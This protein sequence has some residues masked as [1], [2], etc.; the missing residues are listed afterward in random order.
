[1]SVEIARRFSA[2]VESAS[3]TNTDATASV[4]TDGSTA[5]AAAATAAAG[6]A[7][8]GAGA[9]AVGAFTGKSENNIGIIAGSIE[10][11]AAHGGG[12]GIPLGGGGHYSTQ[13]ELHVRN[14]PGKTER[15]GGSGGKIGAATELLARVRGQL[16]RSE[17]RTKGASGGVSHDI[18]PQR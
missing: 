18:A 3:S 6:G 7:A 2:T 11:G 9:S 1:M 16:E 8:V 5:P 15:G 14:L 12:G 10:G 4:G 17:Q 13:P